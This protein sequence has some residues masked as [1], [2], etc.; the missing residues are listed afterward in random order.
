MSSVLVTGG[1]GRLGR[2]VVDRLL[3]GG[4][5]VRVLTHRRAPEGSSRVDW[6]SGDLVTG[7][8]IDAAVAG[9]DAIVHC[10]TTNGRKDVPAGEQLIAAAQR[11][12]VRQRPHATTGTY[13]ERGTCTST[14][15]CSSAARAARHA[16]VGI[17]AAA[18][19]CCAACHSRIGSL[20]NHTSRA[21]PMRRASSRSTRPPRRWVRRPE[22][23]SSCHASR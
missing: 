11:A 4:A 16:A 9:V 2:A 8:G 20:T 23:T 1:T 10:A 12:G 19:G 13:P 3:T 14:G 6:A 17:R 7:A 22:N 18:P 15:P 5:A 21:A